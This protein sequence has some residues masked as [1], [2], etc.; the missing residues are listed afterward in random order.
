MIS[1]SQN[2]KNNNVEGCLIAIGLSSGEIFDFCKTYLGIIKVISVRNVSVCWEKWG[3]L[4][5]R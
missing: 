3:K 4:L 1:L 2:I 5:N